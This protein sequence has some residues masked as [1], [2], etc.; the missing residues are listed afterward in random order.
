[1]RTD[2]HGFITL[3]FHFFGFC[4]VVVVDHLSLSVPEMTSLAAAFRVG[5]K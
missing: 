3:L 4:C 1:M 2:Q 5:S